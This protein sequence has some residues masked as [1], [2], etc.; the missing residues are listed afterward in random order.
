[1]IWRRASWGILGMRV[2]FI[3]EHL[4]RD[5]IWYIGEHPDKDHPTERCW[6]N[7]ESQGT[8]PNVMLDI[9]LVWRLR[10]QGCCFV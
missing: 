5:H 7:L 1:M 9:C 4:D 2:W 10:G 6:E 3:G 8:G